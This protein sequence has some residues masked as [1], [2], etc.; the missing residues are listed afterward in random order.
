LTFVDFRHNIESGFLFI[1]NSYVNQLTERGHR[2]WQD[3]QTAVQDE[4]QKAPH[5]TEEKLRRF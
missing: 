3:V 2:E 4:N 1:L 5:S